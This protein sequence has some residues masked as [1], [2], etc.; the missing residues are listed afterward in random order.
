VY[1]RRH[2]ARTL[3]ERQDVRA[4]RLH[5]I[6]RDQERN[7]RRDAI[8]WAT[9]VTCERSVARQLLDEACNDLV[10]P[11]PLTLTRGGALQVTAAARVPRRLFIRYY[12]IR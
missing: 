6:A 4:H 11:L 12:M 8:A 1:G 10:R 3:S 2:L 9:T 5:F 7:Y